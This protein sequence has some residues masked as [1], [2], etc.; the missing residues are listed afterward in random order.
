L[1]KFKT[2]K[3]SLSLIAGGFGRV[4]CLLA[5]QRLLTGGDQRDDGHYN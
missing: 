2:I 5:K 4:L 3:N 1:G